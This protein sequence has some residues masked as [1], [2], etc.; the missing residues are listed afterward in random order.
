MLTAARLREVLSY[1][2]A[3]GLFRW[4][5]S[6]DGVKAGSFAGRTRGRYNQ[7]CVHRKF[8]QASHLA[9]LYMTDK[10]PK[11]E[12]NYIDGNR[13][14]TRWGNLREITPSQRRA[15][16]P[17]R[18]KLGVKGVWITKNGKY[19]ARISVNAKKKYLGSFETLEEASA[20]YAKA[21]KSA[22]GI[23]ARAR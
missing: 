15:I 20:A 11:R 1:D 18:N 12:I 2:P 9:W 7:I 8:Y 13:F 5:A 3:T 19:V 22:F 14:D 6:R 23:F 21:A 4:R 16:A 17:T 10:W